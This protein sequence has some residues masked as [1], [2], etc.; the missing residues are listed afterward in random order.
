MNTVLQ[1]VV[2]DKLDAAVANGDIDAEA[3]AKARRIMGFA[4]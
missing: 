3:A 2:S 4:E 1:E